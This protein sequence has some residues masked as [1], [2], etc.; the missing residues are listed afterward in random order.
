MDNEKTIAELLIELK[1]AK[2]NIKNALSRKGIEVSNDMTTFADDIDSIEKKVS[3]PIVLSNGTFTSVTADYNS[4]THEYSMPDISFLNCNDFSVTNVELPSEVT[5]LPDNCLKFC[6]I[7]SIDLSNIKTIGRYALANTAIATIVIPSTVEKV[8]AYAFDNSGL[9]SVTY[10]ITSTAVDSRAF[11]NTVYYTNK[12]ANVTDELVEGNSLIVVKPEAIEEGT[13]T[14]PEG[15]TTI[16]PGA[17]AELDT[18]TEV[19]IPEGVTTI[20]NNAFEDTGLTSVTLPSTI[21]EIG[22]DTFAGSSLTGSVTLPVNVETV[23]EGAF[24]GTNITQVLTDPENPNEIEFGIDAFKDTPYLNNMGITADGGALAVTSDQITDLTIP[25]TI[26]ITNV[27]T[28]C[29]TTNNTL[30]TITLNEPINCIKSYAFANIPNL[31]SFTC[32]SVDIVEAHAFDGNTAFTAFNVG[33][34]KEIRDYAFKN[35]AIETFDI[36]EGL[37][38]M[39]NN[40]FDGNTLL[41]SFLMDRNKCINKMDNAFDGSA[42]ERLRVKV[43]TLKNTFITNLTSLTKCEIIIDKFPPNFGA[44][45]NLTNLEE[46]VLNCKEIDMNSFNR[47]SS[48]TNELSIELINVEKIGPSCFNYAINMPNETFYLPN[49][50]KSIGND[51]FKNA[52]VNNL[53]IGSGLKEINSFNNLTVLGSEGLTI[54][55]NIKKVGGFMA[56]NT[57]ALTIEN[58]VEEIMSGTIKFEFAFKQSTGFTSLN[59]PNSVKEVGYGSFSGN[60]TLEDVSMSES[61]NLGRDAFSGCTSLNTI[62]DQ[63]THTLLF[64]KIGSTIPDGVI[65]LGPRSIKSYTGDAPASVTVL[66]FKC[67][68]SSTGDIN[69]LG[70]VTR[71]EDYA[72]SNSTMTVRFKGNIIPDTTY[73]EYFS[74]CLSDLSCQQSDNNKTWNTYVCQYYTDLQTVVEPGQIIAGSLFKVIDNLNREPTIEDPFVVE[75]PETGDL[76]CQV[77]E[78]VTGIG[79]M[80][81][82]KYQKAVYLPNSVKKIGTYG[83]VNGNMHLKDPS[84]SQLEYV[85]YAAYTSKMSMSNGKAMSGLDVDAFPQTNNL[86]TFQNDSIIFAASGNKGI[87]GFKFPKRLHINISSNLKKFFDTCIE[88]ECHLEST[89]GSQ[90]YIGSGSCWFMMNN[91]DGTSSGNIWF[92]INR[93][94]NITLPEETNI[95]IPMYNR[96]ST[97]ISFKSFYKNIPTDPKYKDYITPFALPNKLLECTEDSTGT[98]TPD[99]IVFPEGHKVVLSYAFNNLYS[100][101]NANITIEKALNIP[102]IVLS[103]TIEEIRGNIFGVAKKQTNNGLSNT[104]AIC[105]INNLKPFKIPASCKKLCTAALIGAGGFIGIDFNDKLEYI[106]DYALFNCGS[107]VANSNTD[108]I[109]NAILPITVPP[110]VTYIGDYAFGKCGYKK[111]EFTNGNAVYGKYLCWNAN[112]LEEVIIPEGVTE[113][114]DYAFYGCTSLKTVKLPSTLKTIGIGAFYGCTSLVSINIPDSVEELKNT[115]FYGCT[116]LDLIHIPNSIKVIGEEVFVNCNALDSHV[117]ELPNCIESIASNAFNL[118]GTDTSSTKKCYIKI[119]KR[120]NSVINSPFDNGRNL[121]EVTWLRN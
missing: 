35:T 57:S 28:L 44:L 29:N 55:S 107:I 94:Q 18:L 72:F 19:V 113:I 51:C 109:K 46:L 91:T 112:K 98:L 6:Q 92:G 83:A 77:P 87:E 45:G 54:P 43:N 8:D 81:F 88:D 80:C 100:G 59:I 33:S 60:T 4:V 70:N 56:L 90:F 121:N 3:I 39:G 11:T 105:Y 75:D 96:G 63:T 102:E 103:S 104:S 73:L 85:G 78:G 42:I 79:D 58:G 9:T 17:L 89:D 111:I 64:L 22:E 74:P 66:G 117:F 27:D 25:S 108:D 41:T 114:P 32:P 2:D 47:S 16:E 67:L 20:G 13:Y 38:Y 1:D 23:G 10:D 5:I 86:C 21:T 50:L 68:Q 14:I 106:G 93:G 120:T 84:N 15:V 110:S 37:E 7:T 36:P 40:V 26:K 24:A 61:T 65:K 99:R 101:N 62:I 71:I 52:I 34:C 69:F 30:T 82:M 95:Y 49:S 53:N 12:M 76:S 97:S 119:D 115:C 118:N 31:V 48:N 116:S